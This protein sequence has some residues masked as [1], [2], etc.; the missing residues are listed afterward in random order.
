MLSLLNDNGNISNFGG[1][2]WNLQGNLKGL[3]TGK[4]LSKKDLQLWHVWCYKKDHC[5][6]LF[7]FPRPFHYYFY[8]Y[9]LRKTGI[10]EFYKT[11]LK[12]TKTRDK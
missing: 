3:G 10:W 2:I 8:K 11:T 5:I 7:P 1:I 6:R 9:L 4:H 12:K